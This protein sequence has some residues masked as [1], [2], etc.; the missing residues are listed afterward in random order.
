MKNTDSMHVTPADRN[1]FVDLG[2]PP[3]EAAALKAESDRIIMEKLAIKETL[4]AQI[5]G[6][7]VEKRLTQVDA[8]EILGTT[9]PRVSDLTNKKTI[10]F[11]IDT[12]IDMVIRTGKRVTLSVR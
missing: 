2:F 7:I 12:L 10:K 1:V 8:A 11:S 6:W 4:M 9:R 3:E 5:S